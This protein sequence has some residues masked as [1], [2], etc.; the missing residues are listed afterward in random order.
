[1]VEHFG[2]ADPRAAEWRI[3]HPGQALQAAINDIVAKLA[4]HVLL[5][6]GPR[7]GAIERRSG[8]RNR[9]LLR[10]RRI[11]IDVGPALTVE[12]DGTRID[13]RDD[14]GRWPA[15]EMLADGF[16]DPVR[17]EV[18]Y[19]NQRSILRAIQPLVQRA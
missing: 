2:R 16:F 6:E 13:G 12:R 14:R 5:T 17:V 3:L 19:D 8:A 9:D 15:V 11:E 7:V 10:Q 18:T 1:G 4:P